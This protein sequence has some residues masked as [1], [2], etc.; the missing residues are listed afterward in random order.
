MGFVT[1]SSAATLNLNLTA[2]NQFAVYLST[3]DAAEGTKIGS[4]AVWATT[5]S[6]SD[7][8]SGSGPFY[9]HVIAVNATSDN[10]LW[11]SPGSLNGQGDNPAGFIGSFS[12]SGSGYTFANGSTTL[13][14]DT[15]DWRASEAGDATTTPAYATIPGWTGATGAPQSYGDNGAGPWGT[16]SSVSG[17][18]KWIWSNPDNGDYAEFSTTITGAPESSTWVMLLSGSAALG[19]V[20]YRRPGT[21]RPMSI[22]G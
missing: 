22:V 3:S 12:I 17:S 4:G 19:F 11:S 14:T 16:V 9:I 15:T 6:F 13:S 20:A 8:L 1:S 2:D 7:T 5:S 18:A 10:G 21:K